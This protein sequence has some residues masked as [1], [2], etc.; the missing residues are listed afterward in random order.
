VGNLRFIGQKVRVVYQYKVLGVW[1][2]SEAA[3]AAVY[4][5]V[6]GQYKIQDITTSG[7][8]TGVPTSANLTPD[9]TI[10]SNDRQILGSDIP[11][12]FGG[13]T[14]TLNYRNF[15]FSF[16][17]YTRQGQFQQSTF[18]A[19]TVDGDQGRARFNTYQRDYWTPT[20]Q[21]NQFANMGLEQDGGRRS[22]AEYMDASYTKI[23]NM[24]LG[25]TLPKKLI[26]KSVRSLRVYVTAT[27]PF[28]WTKFIGWDPE[29][30]D[31]NSYGAVDFRTRTFLFGLN[32]GL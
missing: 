12:W 14:N 9:N 11:N 20:R 1:Q 10:N 27:N 23:S 15:D 6:P 19:Q 28:I 29:T 17:I 3:Q 22:A 32:L 16:T 25:Y 7:L 31:L 8:N 26:G 2:A 18:F 5:Q 24:G 21:S 30:A 13:I 4:K